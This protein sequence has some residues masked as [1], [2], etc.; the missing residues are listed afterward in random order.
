MSADRNL[1]FGILAL[2]L[3]FVTR[4]Q[5]VEGMNKWVL[6]KTK[7]LGELFVAAKAIELDHFKLLDALVDK[8]I[9]K[10]SGD[11]QKSIQKLSSIDP[12]ATQQLRAIEDSELAATVIHLTD[13]P[14]AT[15]VPK[16][17]PQRTSSRFRIIRP[18]ARGGLGEVF[19]AQDTELSREVALKEIQDRY[20]DDM[21]SRARFMR[22]AEI[23]GRLEHPGIVPVYGLGTYDDGRPFYAMKFVKGQSLQNAIDKFHADPETKAAK[24]LVTG[25]VGI[26]FRELLGVSSMSVM[27]FTML[28]HVAFSTVI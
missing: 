17:T 25:N 5:L 27:Q 2:Q 6:D 24:S 9:E 14:N 10:H 22:E 11:A 28:I 1:L 3:N 13:D 15:V 19:L 20:A 23:T 18:H 8:H 7:T 12:Y 21:E 4:D 26:R 16:I